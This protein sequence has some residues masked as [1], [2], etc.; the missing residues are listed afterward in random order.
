MIKQLFLAGLLTVGAS[1]AYAQQATTP[2]R[3]AD[4]Q[5]AAMPS[6]ADAKKLIG[7]NV[8]NPQNETVGEIESVYINA[9]G[10]VDSV[11]LGVGGF[12]GVGERHV[13]VAWKDLRISDNGEKVVINANKDQLKAM[14]PYTYRDAKMRGQ[15]FSDT[16]PYTTANDRVTPAPADRMASTTATEST[17]D[18]NA[19]GAVSGNAM[20]GA[21]VH[22]AAKETVG[23]VEDVYLDA[24]GAVDSI[25]VSVGGFL[26]VGSK[27]V[28]VKWSELKVGRDGKDL[29][30]TTNWTKDSL[31]AMPDY[32]YER[33]KPVRSGG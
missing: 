30:L 27:N 15:V 14:A 33:R 12:L 8:K 4:P 18:F 23:S 1:A 20:I 25:V 19:R 16:G 7:R 26:G 21:K 22:N 24:K 10:K 28:A 6:G 9:D 2:P 31:K 17:G 29:M 32:K 11:I 13:R 5:V 3:A